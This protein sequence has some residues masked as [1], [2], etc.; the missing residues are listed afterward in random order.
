[1]VAFAWARGSDPFATQSGFEVWTRT[2]RAE[3]PWQVVYAFTDE[4]SSGVLG[5]RAE[6]FAD[7]T[8]DGV[9]DALTFED[10]GGS[11]ACGVWR[12]VRMGRGD[13]TEIYAKQTCDAQ[14][15]IL[16]RE[17]Q[18]RASVYRPGD[19]HCCPSAY[20][21]TTLRWSGEGWDVV[22]RSTTPA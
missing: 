16:G 2:R 7:V 1:V 3:P 4:P 13:A 6:A 10:L 8:G 12:V 22:D 5:V 14:M 17:L 11:G 9:P 19:A 18:I 21:T 15:R 20:R